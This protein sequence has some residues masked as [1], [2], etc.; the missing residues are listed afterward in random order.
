MQE[1]LGCPEN[2]DENDDAEAPLGVLLALCEGKKTIPVVK[3]GPFKIGLLLR[4]YTI[5]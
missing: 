2:C 3:F 1:S 4:G 5:T